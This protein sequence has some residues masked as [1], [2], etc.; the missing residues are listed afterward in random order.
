[1]SGSPSQPNEVPGRS[2]PEPGAA[3]SRPSELAVLTLPFDQYQRYRLVADLIGELQGPAPARILDVGGRTALLRAFLP[4]Q[5]V[6]LVDLEPAQVRGLVLGDGSRLPFRAHSFDVVCAFDTLE[7]VPPDRRQAFV[8]EC[9][10]VSRAHVILAGPYR[11]PAVD[12]AEET[13]RAFLS[14]KLGIEHRYLNEHRAHGLPLRE[15]TEARLCELGARVASVGHG[16]LGR[17]LACMCAE[18]YMDHDPL[19][20]PLAQRFFQFYNTQLYRSDARPPVYRHAVVAAFGDA[21]LPAGQPSAEP[22]APLDVG[23]S[24]SD[25]GRW[26]FEYDS[27]RDCLEPELER[28]RGI[29]ADLEQ[30]LAGHQERLADTRADLQ[31]HVASLAESRA[32]R[33]R[34][35][36]EQARERELLAADLAEHARSLAESEALRAQE[37]SQGQEARALLEADLLEHARSLEDLRREQRELREERADFGR[38]ARLLEAELRAELARHVEVQ[39]EL[40]RTLSETQGAAA[41]IQ[42]ELVRAGGDIADLVQRVQAQQAQLADLR[43]TLRDRWANLKRALGPKV[44]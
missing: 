38:Q 3:P 14:G 32:I 12:E 16:H 22:E 8:D 17:W 1:M 28:L 11:S 27:R 31:Q 39:G 26:L 36:R 29:I 43:A 15:E 10:R 9:A 21:R 24:L 40:V 20:R 6:E 25:F 44:E 5:R 4:G 37:R 23:R 13:L 33:E 19:L 7:H 18:L 42:A 30:D 41:Q 2:S 34:A 35:E